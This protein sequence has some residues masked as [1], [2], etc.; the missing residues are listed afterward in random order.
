MDK[1]VIASLRQRL[2]LGRAL[3]FSLTDEELRIR[4]KTLLADAH[5]SVPVEAVDRNESESR[6]R[7][8]WTRIL[9]TLGL[10][11]AI[12]SGLWSARL[13]PALWPASGPAAGWAALALFSISVLSGILFLA[14]ASESLVFYNAFTG[15]FLFAVRRDRPN[16]GEV[17]AFVARL[18]DR[19]KRRCELLQADLER[20]SVAK[21]LLALRELCEK[22]IISDEEF[23]SKK[24]ELMEEIMR[25]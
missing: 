1:P 21:E 10:A 11:G 12:V 9:L 17:D 23:A 15:D 8:G 22:K 25:D 20:P 5:R 2:P 18:K 13:A 19:S 16:R 24:S 3:E 14:L 4:T 6:N 7:P